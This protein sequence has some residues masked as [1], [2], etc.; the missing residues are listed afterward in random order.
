ME[1]LM[2]VLTKTK[3]TLEHRHQETQDTVSFR[4]KS[5]EIKN[6]KPGQ[7]LHY[8]LEHPH[9]DSRGKERYFTISSAPFEGHIQITTRFSEKKGS[10]FKKELRDMAVGGEIEA[11]GLEGDFVVEDPNKRLVF[12]A[13]GIG[14]TP[15][16]AILLALDHAGTPINVDLLYANRDEDFPYQAELKTLAGK[17]PTFRV[18]YFT[19][20]KRLDERAIGAAVGD[21]GKPIFYVSGPEPMVEAFEKVLKG[22]SV[23]KSRV[24]TDY[25]PGYSWP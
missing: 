3:L 7:Y 11:D 18:H 21:L 19:G 10:S 22:M 6:W 24:K 23:P 16:R 13:G 2:S 17:H 25:F 15:Y 5:G 12:I 9:P 1:A 8:T 14:V 20:S 4:F